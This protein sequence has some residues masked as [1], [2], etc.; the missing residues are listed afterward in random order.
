MAQLKKC[1]ASA[2]TKVHVHY[3]KGLQAVGTV[4]QTPKGFGRQPQDQW[5]FIAALPFYAGHRGNITLSNEGTEPGTLTVFDQVR[6]SWSGK[7]CSQVQSHPRKAELR[8]TVDF[9]AVENRQTE[10]GTVLK[11]QLAKL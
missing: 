9:K 3:C 5:T 8:F 10:F 2:N 11:R 4:D 7:S 1:E 6:F